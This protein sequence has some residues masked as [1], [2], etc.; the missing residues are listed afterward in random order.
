MSSI[1]S[2]WHM[3]NDMVV[4]FDVDGEQVPELQGRYAD[5]YKQVLERADDGTL[6]YGLWERKHLYAQ[7]LA[8]QI[9]DD[10]NRIPQLEAENTRLTELARSTEVDY[11]EKYIECENA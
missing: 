1:T 4:V 3:H 7:S 11:G 5:V 6:F 8:P 9:A 10:H 2:A